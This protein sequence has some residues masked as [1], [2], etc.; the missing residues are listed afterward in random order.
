MF[1]SSIKIITLV[2]ILLV[3][4]AYINADP[5]I[6]DETLQKKSIGLNLEYIEDIGKAITFDEIRSDKTGPTWIKSTKKNLGFGFTK[7]AYWVRFS[8]KNTTPDEI[9]FYLEQSYPP[10]DHIFLYAPDEKGNYRIIKSGDHYPFKQRPVKYRTFVFPLTMKPHGSATYYMRFESSGSINIELSI[11]TY[12][13]FHDIKDEEAVFLWIFYGIFLVMFVNYLVIFLATR[14][15]SYFFYVLYVGSFALFIMSMKGMAMQY[16]WPNNIWLGNYAIPISMIMIIVSII[17]FALFFVGVKKISPVLFRLLNATTI[18]VMVSFAFALIFS[19]YNFTINFTNILTGIATSLGLLI[20]FYVTIAKKSRQALFFMVSFLVF[21]IGVILMVLQLRGTIPSNALTANGILL[22]AVFQ[23]IALSIGLADKINA[24]RREVQIL[25]TDL[26]KKITERTEELRA[27]MEEME[28]M[29]D[30]LAETNRELEQ[31]QH[32]A[33]IDM[34]MAANVQSSLFPKE[35]PEVD[36][37]DIAYAFIPI[38]GVSGDLYDFY[39]HDKVLDGIALFDV[40]GHGIAS[41]L[42]T[43]IA[44]SVFHRN[45]NKG[46]ENPLH[47]VIEKINRDLI[48]E[49]G[50]ADNY[51]TGILVRF[52]SDTVEYVNAGHSDLLYRDAAT[53][54]VRPVCRDGQDMRGMFLG[55]AAVNEPY[56]S[57]KFTIADNDV[58]LLYTDCLYESKNSDGIEFGLE[59]LSASLKNARGVSATDIRNEILND[60]YGFMGDAFPS[61]DL[62]FIVVKRKI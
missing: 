40:S 21:L 9:K 23:A 47:E 34:G 33:R 18:A 13:S 62:T 41:G 60:F 32:I 4:P 14:D 59:N 45:F 19:G 55:V 44:R 30:T 25:N 27:A 46:K 53:G 22:G 24:M 16:L 42:I 8:L 31:A 5:I 29:N 61:D 26:E 20:V 6:I 2:S 38:S 43:M 11:M 15:W 17:Q 37:W 49:M 36:G 48:N 10:T 52:N 39:T 12:D 7:N 56:E 50:Q 58:L 57:L 35:P 28:S 3:I 1:K 51:L 54:S